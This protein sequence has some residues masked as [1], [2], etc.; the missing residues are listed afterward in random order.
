MKSKKDLVIVGIGELLWDMFPDEK[1]AGGAPVNFVYHATTLGAE[2]YAISA[3]GNDRPGVDIINLMNEKKIRHIIAKVDH[4]TGTVV[5]QLNR[6]IPTYT[7]T[8]DVAWDFIP[9]TDQIVEVARN[10]DAVC[11]GTLAQRSATSRVTIRKFL[12]LVPEDSFRIL[13]INLRAPFYSYEL[14]EESI[15][16]CNIL[17]LNDDELA[18][19]KDMF[20][21]DITDD[22]EACRWLM[23]TYHLEY[24]IL[25]AGADYSMVFSPGNISFLETPRVEVVDTVGAG[26]SFT[27]AFITSLLSG[28]TLEEAHSTAVERAAAVCTVAG[29][30]LDDL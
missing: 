26:D 2:G 22:R 7:I 10:S 21:I 20:H 3:V 18:I 4:P 9:L 11:F 30:W 14:I 24:V 27:G 19:V 17:K 28:D 16:L 12:S 13:D 6:G 25:T 5:V 29:A 8:R 1:K 15:Q 23:D